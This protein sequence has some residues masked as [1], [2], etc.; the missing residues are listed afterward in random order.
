MLEKSA[1]TSVKKPFKNATKVFLLFF[2]KLEKGD[3]GI[4]VNQKT[5]K[6]IRQNVGK[7][8]QNLK[9]KTKLFFFKSEKLRKKLQKK[10]K[11]K[12]SE[13]SPKT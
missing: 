6:N 3:I 12:M 5:R 4:I 11:D 2:F 13:K 7:I 9:N 8:A 1:K 10:K